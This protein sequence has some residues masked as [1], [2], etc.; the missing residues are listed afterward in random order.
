MCETY[1]MSPPHTHMHEVNALRLSGHLLCCLV[2]IAKQTQ[3][4]SCTHLAYSQ[5]IFSCYKVINILM[6]LA[7]MALQFLHIPFAFLP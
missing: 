1:V 7:I 6:H 2:F 4:Y 5:I 3:N